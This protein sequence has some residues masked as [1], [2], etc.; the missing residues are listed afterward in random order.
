MSDLLDD[1]F[2]RYKELMAS[3]NLVTFKGKI[4]YLILDADSIGELCPLFEEAELDYILQRERQTSE[5]MSYHQFKLDGLKQIEV[6]LHLKE[7]QK[8]QA[9]KLVVAYEKKRAAVEVLFQQKFPPLTPI[10][11]LK[12]PLNQI[13]IGILS[14]L[15]IILILASL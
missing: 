1:H 5:G 2:G 13:A 10:A 4:P 11:K 14:I 3:S 8:E 15:L 7:E 9:D 6:L 12:E